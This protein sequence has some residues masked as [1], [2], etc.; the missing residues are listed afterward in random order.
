MCGEPVPDA[1]G[2]RQPRLPSRTALAHVGS[3]RQF[4]AWSA[5]ALGS[6]GVAAGGLSSPA[7]A[8]DGT[9]SA[10]PTPAPPTPAVSAP[11][12]PTA[13]MREADPLGG[14]GFGAPTVMSV[15][16]HYDDDLLFAGSR[17]DEAINSGEFVRT[18][19]LTGGDAGRGAGYA[20][21]RER[22]I[23]RAYNEMRGST[24]GWTSTDVTLET[25][26]R[27]TS[28]RPDDSDRITLVFFHL[29]DGNIGGQG[30]PATGHAS[31]LKLAE[32][33][34][35]SIGDLGGTY[36]LT[37]QQLID[38]I[39]LLINRFAP[40]TILTSVPGD[41]AKWSA[42]DHADHR[43]TGNATRA[44]WRQTGYPV[45]LVAYAVGYQT[46]GYS[47]NVGGAP[48]DRRIDAFSTYAADD[49]VVGACTNH[50]TCLRVPRFGAWLQR[51][52]SRD[53]A[54]LWSG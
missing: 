33:E 51:E 30:F 31:L 23:K 36:S 2:G 42:G 17:L 34:I 48:L 47:A 28:W 38:S 49:P 15:W 46:E 7:R 13:Q 44:A 8:A 16:A 22:G 29:P 11:A 18:V 24:A 6:L 39:A 19:F 12:Q 14:A 32:N 26:A 40:A 54:E 5:V 52:Y 50:Q 1:S 21:G 3:R 35:G 4:L 41:S 9:G 10:S 53:E 20:Q 27:V 43:T 45:D 37:W 25:G